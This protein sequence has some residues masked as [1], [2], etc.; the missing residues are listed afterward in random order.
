MISKKT[1]ENKLKELKPLLE[2]QYKVKK[3]GYFGSYA[4][5]EASEDSDVDI[6]VEFSGDVGWE[7]LDLK[8]LL[9]NNLNTEV[10]LVTM[11][12][13]KPQLKDEILKDVI[14]Q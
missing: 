7:F 9:E 2:K 5:N 3:L 1:L 4:R 11:N 8:D 13:L 6:L 12:A 10:D 14:Y